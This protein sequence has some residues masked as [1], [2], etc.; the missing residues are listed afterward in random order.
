MGN[1]E[2]LMA[3][4]DDGRRWEL[5]VRGVVVAPVASIS[6]RNG[7][8]ASGCGGQEAMGMGWGLGLAREGERI[9]EGEKKGGNDRRCMF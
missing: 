6:R 9:G 2:G 7:D 5:T 3:E 1:E 8:G 4:D